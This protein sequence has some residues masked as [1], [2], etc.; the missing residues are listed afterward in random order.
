MPLLERGTIADQNEETSLP[1]VVAISQ[2]NYIPWKG[3]FDLIAR[4]DEFILLDEVQYTS[5]DWRNRNRIKTSQG[6]LWLTI[7]VNSSGKSQQKISEVLVTDRSW[8]RRHWK[9]IQRAYA[10]APFFSLYEAQLKELFFECNTT[11]LSQINRTFLTKLCGLLE[12]RTKISTSSDFP[13]VEGKSLRLLDLCKKTGA[14]VYLS[15]PKAKAYLNQAAFEEENVQVEWMDYSEY[16]PY[17]QVHPP[18]DHFVSVLDLLFCVGPHF[19]K[20]F[21]YV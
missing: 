1:K 21:K 6:P 4:S 3:Y 18:F 5:R 12:I 11:S 13:L 19:R 16:L 17:Q 9:S 8:N 10:K 14:D 2:S 15:G 7:P 20:Y